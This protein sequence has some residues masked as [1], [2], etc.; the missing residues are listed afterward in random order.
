MS[1]ILRPLI[2]VASILLFAPAGSPGQTP[3]P[4]VDSLVRWADAALSAGNYRDAVRACADALRRF[5]DD[6]VAH[7]CAKK[8]E[9]YLKEVLSGASA[10]LGAGDPEGARDRCSAVLVLTP[11]DKE[12]N[13]CAAMARIQIAAHARDTLKLEQARGFLARGDHTLASQS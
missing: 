7:G 13:A 9:P 2:V 10:S 8:V 6:P 11:L 12:A 1:P 5:P 4:G 3:S